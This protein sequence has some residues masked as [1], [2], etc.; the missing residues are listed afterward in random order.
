MKTFALKVL[1][2]VVVMIIGLLSVA[3]Y[4][5]SQGLAAALIGER[6]LGAAQGIIIGAVISILT[7]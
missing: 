7:K 2:A 1:I 4:G 5:E 3:A 6:V